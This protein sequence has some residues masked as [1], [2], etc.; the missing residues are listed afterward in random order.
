MKKIIFLAAIF[1]AFSFAAKAQ[2][3]GYAEYGVSNESD[4]Q[5][6]IVELVA[7]CPGNCTT[8]YRYNASAPVPTGV[9]LVQVGSGAPTTWVDATT[10]VDAIPGCPVL[11]PYSMSIVCYEGGVGNGIGVIYSPNC[12]AGPSSIDVSGCCPGAGTAEIVSSGGSNPAWIL[13]IY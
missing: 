2:Q 6:E 11:E 3:W 9:N 4:C 5:L 1:A 13:N 12:S 8:L 7:V 10:G